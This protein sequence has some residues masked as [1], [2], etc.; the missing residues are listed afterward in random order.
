MISKGSTALSDMLVE[1]GQQKRTAERLGIPPSL[2]IRWRK[3]EQKPDGRYRALLEDK[4]SI[5]WRLWDEPVE[6]QE[7]AA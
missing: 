2:L 3:G 6:T 1:R 4:L 5:P 7:G